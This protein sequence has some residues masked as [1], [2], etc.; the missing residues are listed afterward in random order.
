[1]DLWERNLMAEF[2]R[3]YHKP[4]VVIYWHLADSYI[5][6]Y[7]SLIRCSVREAAHIIDGMI[8]HGLDIHPRRVAAD[9]HG[10]SEVVF[11]FAHLLGVELLTRVKS[12]NHY[13]FYKASEAD[14][15]VPL[16]QYVQ[17]E[18]LN[19]RLI[20]ENY[21]NLLRV[22]VSIAK[23]RVVASQVIQTLSNYS[24][25]N[26][27]HLAFKEL[28]KAIRTL[29]L[30]DYLDDAQLRRIVLRGC[31]KVESWNDYADHDFYGYGGKIRSHD[32]EQQEKAMLYLQLL[33]NVGV[34]WVE[35]QMERALA[36]LEKKGKKVNLEHLGYLSPMMQG[37]I[38]PYGE[39]NL[40]DLDR[41]IA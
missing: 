12:L 11:A 19:K 41:K 17:T 20:I 5:A 38:N 37:L 24:E 31:N 29:Y 40:Y 27:L 4:G 26:K 23:G 6:V 33:M 8:Y 16:E 18:V 3:R 15:Y 22:I 36:A 28:G 10:Q 14:Q 21:R 34:Y 1:M 2:H 32:P 13:V 7:S 39:Y 25:D 35:R 9:S 30:L